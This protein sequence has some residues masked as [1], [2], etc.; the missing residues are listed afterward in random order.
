M[1]DIIDNYRGLIVKTYKGQIDINT[2]QY[3]LMSHFP[4]VEFGIFEV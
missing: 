2:S 4:Q 3:H 1:C